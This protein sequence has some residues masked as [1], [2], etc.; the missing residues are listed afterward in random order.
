MN[1]PKNR[2]IGGLASFN[3]RLEKAARAILAEA[4]P[5]G[6]RPDPVFEIAPHHIGALEAVI[7]DK[8][9]AYEASEINEAKQL[10]F[11]ALKDAVGP[12]RRADAI[13]AAV[14]ELLQAVVAHELEAAGH[15]PKKTREQ[16][17]EEQDIRN[18]HWVL[19]LLTAWLDNNPIADLN[20]RRGLGSAGRF[21]VALRTQLGD[22][23][24]YR[25]R[26]LQDVLAQ[27]AMICCE[28]ADDDEEK[29]RT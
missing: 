25:G 24:I 7:R 12:G 3:L 9:D 2:R 22:T 16:E 18:A 29:E 8:P 17:I 1:T 5:G 13:V 15:A 19:A 14:E 20:L 11:S 28:P 4:V 27:A 26:T 10:V 21:E 23:E 6:I